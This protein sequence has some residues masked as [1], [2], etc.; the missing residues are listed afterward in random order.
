V[1]NQLMIWRKNAKTRPVDLEVGLSNWTRALI[2]DPSSCPEIILTT[3]K[4]DNNE[5]V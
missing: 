1:L 4:V 5:T 2:R 3:I